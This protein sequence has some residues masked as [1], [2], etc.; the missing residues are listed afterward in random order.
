MVGRWWGRAGG[1]QVEILKKSSPKVLLF[2]MLK[3]WGVLLPEIKMSMLV[4]KGNIRNGKV[5]CWRA[6]HAKMP[7]SLSSPSL[8]VAGRECLFF[9]SFCRRDGES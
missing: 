5:Q 7:Q 6:C 2:K 9:L 1:F 8:V 4:E 3:M